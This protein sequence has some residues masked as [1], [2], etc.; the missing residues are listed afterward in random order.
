MVNGRSHRSCMTHCTAAPCGAPAQMQAPKCAQVNVYP[1]MRAKMQNV[2]WQMAHLGIFTNNLFKK[3]EKA[4]RIAD[5]RMKNIIYRGI[6]T[7]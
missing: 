5:G 1:A 6:T 4:F 3:I 7:L 2:A